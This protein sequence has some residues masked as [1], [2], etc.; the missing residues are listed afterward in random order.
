[1]H[2]ELSWSPV[3]TVNDVYNCNYKYLLHLYFKFEFYHTTMFA[4]CS[5]LTA[6]DY[7]NP[8]TQGQLEMQFSPV[9]TTVEVFTQNQPASSHKAFL[10]SAQYP[11]T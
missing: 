6:A 4:I 8:S 11:K 7:P 2:A 5:L 9:S 10:I 3:S 1:M